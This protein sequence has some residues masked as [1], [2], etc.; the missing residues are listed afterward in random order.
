MRD[1]EQTEVVC[2]YGECMTSQLR[3]DLIKHLWNQNEDTY[4]IKFID[5]HL[6]CKSETLK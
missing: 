6:C 4:Y 3:N 2:A 5:A 1:D